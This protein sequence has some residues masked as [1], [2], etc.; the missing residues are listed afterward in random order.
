MIFEQFALPSIDWKI[1]DEE[2]CKNKNCEG[3]NCLF[4]KK[5]DVHRNIY[6][7][8]LYLLHKDTNKGMS[9]PVIFTS[10]T[11]G[12]CFYVEN[13]DAIAV[14]PTMAE[15]CVEEKIR[16]LKEQIKALEVSKNA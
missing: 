8:A 15:V 16:M 7:G 9:C 1:V 12:I 14:L 2:F 3:V 13:G 5:G 10:P 6:Q 11:I 4:K